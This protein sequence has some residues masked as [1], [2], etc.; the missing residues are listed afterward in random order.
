MSSKGVKRK[1]VVLDIP[2]KLRILDRLENGHKCVGFAKEFGVGKS[3]ISD[4][5]SAKDK[6]REFAVSC[7]GSTDGHHTMK[8]C[9]DERLD[10]ALFTW[11]SQ[12]RH[13]GTPL[14]GPM[15][16]EKALWF[17]H[18]LNPDDD[19]TFTASEGW[20]QRWKKRNGIRQLS[21]NFLHLTVSEIVKVTTARSKVK[22]RSHHD[23]A[24][25]KPLPMSLS[26][27]NF[28]HLMVSEIQPG[29]TFSRQC[30]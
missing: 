18:Q 21:I 22:S 24:H 15:V 28:L 4:I 19:R 11:F 12:E 14:S 1:Q 16:K 10:K 6:I 5:K 9:S 17:H 26:N 27:I 8:P 29:Q 23:V 3:T 25:L 13:R 2:T 7:E 30:L 20:L